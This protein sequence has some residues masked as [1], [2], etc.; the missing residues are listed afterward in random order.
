MSCHCRYQQQRDTNN[1]NNTLK[2]LYT[3]ILCFSEI[4][5]IH[6]NLKKSLSPTSMSM[7]MNACF[8]SPTKP[9]SQILNLNKML[10]VRGRRQ[11]LE[12]KQSFKEV[13]F[14]IFDDASNTMR[15]FFVSRSPFT[16]V[17]RRQGSALNKV[18]QQFPFCQ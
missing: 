18:F 2:I 10:K 5:S 14:P 4:F 7:L 11:R 17:R 15:V 13:L 6:R 3:T 9:T 16:T 8:M 12:C 1:P